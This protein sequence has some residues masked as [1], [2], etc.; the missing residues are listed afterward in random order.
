MFDENYFRNRTQDLRPNT[1][2]YKFT[3]LVSTGQVYS[4]TRHLINRWQ[5]QQVAQHM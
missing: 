3:K 5:H 4:I 2:K 1:F